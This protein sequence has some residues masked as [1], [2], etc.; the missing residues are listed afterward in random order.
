MHYRTKN[1]LYINTEIVCVS[2]IPKWYMETTTATTTPPQQERLESER[3]KNE[4][5]GQW[6]VGSL[7][8]DKKQ[9]LPATDTSVLICTN[10]IS[11]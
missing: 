7:G 2:V 1:Y 8:I 11:Q 3:N 6:G 10:R 4:S 9:Y 5:G